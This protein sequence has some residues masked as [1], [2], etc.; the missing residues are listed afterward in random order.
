ML[1]PLNLLLITALASVVMLFVL[2]SLVRSRI[3][4][5][6]EWVAA[7][8]L[9]IVSLV[10]YA[11]RGVAPDV[12]SVVLANTLLAAAV[13]A[14]LAGFRRFA[15]QQVPVKWLAAGLA[16]VAAGI[17][18]FYYLTDWMAARIVLVSIFHSIA[19]FA[20]A[21]TVASSAFSSG[22]RYPVLFTKTT[23]LLFG[24][25]HAFRGLVYAAGVDTLVSAQQATLWNV[26]FLSI[27]VI[28][29]PVLTLGA[30]MMVHDRMMSEAESAAN[31]DFLTGAWSRRAFFAFAEKEMARLHR[32]GDALSLL[33]LDVDHFKSINDKY[34]HAAG[35]RV[36]MDLTLRAESVIRNIDY[37]G[38]L[39]GEEFAVLLTD[40]S[41][42]E[43]NA[44][45]E[46]LRA[47]LDATV[48]DPDKIADTLTY[49]VSIGVAQ[50]HPGESFSHLLQRADAALYKAK[51]A[52]R[53]R[54]ISAEAHH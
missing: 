17:A 14:V 21:R 42:D 3:G 19:C 48:S 50:L 36:L 34:G 1:T 29:L 44:V 13:S 2:W 11:L 6:R 7:N 46:R 10:L 24:L 22:N 52:G 26:L 5:V 9:A 23:A 54:V 8:V 38:R 45:A 25:G 4:G 51:Q 28:V 40:T 33:V 31:S 32:T 30:T 37:L 47:V 41:L 35:D 49:A 53:N 27:G 39:G 18:T 15:N 43:A 16:M 12:L 20:I